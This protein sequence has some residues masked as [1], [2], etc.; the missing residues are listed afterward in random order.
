LDAEMIK[1]YD[2]ELQTEDG[3]DAC[4]SMDQCPLG[5]F[6]L[7]TDHESALASIAEQ[8]RERLI[9]EIDKGGYSG[10]H[11]IVEAIR[12]ADLTDLTP[13]SGHLANPLAESCA[14]SLTHAERINEAGR[15]M[16][17]A[18]SYCPSDM[19]HPDKMR[20][21]AAYFCEQFGVLK[22]PSPP[23]AKEQA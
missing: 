22:F 16:M 12:T 6:I 20:W 13:G 19:S 21:M 4:A 17:K 10:Y 11:S 15:V 7:F 1:R 14:P 3:Y 2:C 23:D 8:V 18:H 5:E 9:S